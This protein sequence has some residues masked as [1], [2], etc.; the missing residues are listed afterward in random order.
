[1]MTKEQRSFHKSRRKELLAKLE[2]NSLVLILGNSLRNKSFDQ[3]Y[4][5]KQNKNLY[6]LTGFKEPS[7]ALLMSNRGIKYCDE[8]SKKFCTTNE[9]LFVQSRNKNLEH[10][11]GKRLGAE[12]VKHEL[13]LKTGLLNSEI[14][15]VLHRN[16]DNGFTKLYLNFS[17]LVSLNGDMQMHLLPFLNN[18]KFYSSNL[19]ISDVTYTLGLMRSIKTDYEIKQITKA[20]DITVESFF[21]TIKNINSNLY[22]YQVQS[23]LEG[24]YISKGASD[25]AFTTIAAAGNNSCTLHYEANRSKLKNGELL[26]IDSGAEYNYYNA[27]IT[28]TIPVNGKFSTE[29]KLIYDLVLKTNKEC[30]KKIKPGVECSYLERYCKSILALGL[31]KLGFIKERNELSKFYTHNLG[32]HL[33]LDTHDAVPFT[34]NKLGV[35]DKLKP[36]N[37]I[38]IEPGLY[39]PDDAKGIP[40]KFR[41]IGIRI[42]DD[43]LV[44]KNGCK[45]L[46]KNLPKE[47]NE[48]ENLIN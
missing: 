25:V 42:E 38:T 21:E 41:G 46:S 19:Q 39:F 36:G 29:Q 17:D 23:M 12:N 22:E 34:K 31:L 11:E 13:D 4:V 7:A 27:D 20:V 15:K 32:H 1:M 3:N 37:I 45:V 24:N 2:K 44:T 43:V 6:Y 16:I 48:I 9:I 33:G 18:L 14:F 26:L 5:F 40:K 10:W 28:R 30:I 8:E 35:I 47:V